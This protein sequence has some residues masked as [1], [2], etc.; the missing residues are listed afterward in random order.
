MAKP[1]KKLGIRGSDTCELI[2]EDC[3]IPADHLIGQPNRGF[4]TLM[5][6]FNYTRPLVAAQALGIAQG[7]LDE[8]LKYV[9]ER[10]QFGRPLASFQGLQWM[11][12]EMALKVEL[13]RTMIYRVCAEIDQR[14]ESKG[15]HA[16][17]LHGQMV[18]LG[19][20]HVR[21]H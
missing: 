3:W 19:H 16:P 21:D 6:T 9:K 17:G 20:G 7:A 13:A 10:V 4:Y 12:A 8:A 2:F 14:P 18:R 1:E 15:H 5:K 11:L